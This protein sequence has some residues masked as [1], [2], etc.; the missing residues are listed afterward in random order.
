MP[1]DKP[2]EK[3]W[4]HLR[5]AICLGDVDAIVDQL[6]QEGI[7]VDYAGMETE[8]TNLKT[9]VGWDA[10]AV[11]DK[12]T[13][14]ESMNF[15]I[16]QSINIYQPQDAPAIDSYRESIAKERWERVFSDMVG[17]A[18]G[19]LGGPSAHEPGHQ[20]TWQEALM[21]A[22]KWAVTKNRAALVY[23]DSLLSGEV[24][25]VVGAMGADREEGIRVQLLYVLNNL[26]GW[27]GEEARA[28]KATLRAVSKGDLPAHYTAD[29]RAA[30]DLAAEEHNQSHHPGRPQITRPFTPVSPSYRET[31]DTA[32]AGMQLKIGE[33]A[34]AIRHMEERGIPDPVVG[35]QVVA[36]IEEAAV[37]LEEAT[38]LTGRA[39]GRAQADAIRAHILSLGTGASSENT[40]TVVAALRNNFPDITERDVLNAIRG[41][42]SGSPRLGRAPTIRTPKAPPPTLKGPA[43][44]PQTVAIRTLALSL[45]ADL[46]THSTADIV[47]AIQPEFPEVDARAVGLSLS[48]TWR[49]KN[50]LPNLRRSSDPPPPPPA[51]PAPR[52][53]GGGTLSDILGS[54]ERPERMK[55][56]L[57]AAMDDPTEMTRR[58][59]QQM[60]NAGAFEREELERIALGMDFE[61]KVWDTQELSADFDVQGFLAPFVGVIRKSD[62]QKGVLL[63]QHY[64]RYYWGFTPD[65]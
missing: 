45:G 13:F 58:Q 54:L 63:F 53:E 37:A 48:R 23:I 60:I 28:A 35:E 36:Q 50:N 44:R 57:P 24:G 15:L 43:P 40:R 17:R 38:T 32:L 16:T 14:Q 1:H 62:G 25:T 11:V 3:E 52:I 64:P 22:R 59:F 8:L 19:R 5:D 21:D 33:I 12:E 29:E 6:Y 31:L 56:L 39:A 9:D 30:W 55:A 46:A 61:G 10:C 42:P 18:S 27:R 49:E 47:Q 7:R 41:L 51:I 2:E 20:Q 65:E 26:S 4:L 34:E